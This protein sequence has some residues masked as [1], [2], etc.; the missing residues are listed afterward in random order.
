L[1]DEE[2]YQTF[3]LVRWAATDGAPVCPRCGGVVFSLACAELRLVFI[4]MSPGLICQ[5]TREKWRGVKTTG[6]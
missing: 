3:K 1:S 2:A 4:T 6:A 5:P